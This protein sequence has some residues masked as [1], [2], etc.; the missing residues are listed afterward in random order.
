MNESGSEKQHLYVELW[1]PKQTWLD[2]SKE[3]RQEYFNKVGGE[4]QKLANEGIKVLGF[5]IN[6]K[7]TP[8]RSKHQY[9]AVWQ[10]PSKKHVEM[11]EE[12]V[13][14]TGWYNYFEQVNARGEL[15]PPPVALEN[16]LRLE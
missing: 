13:S 9:V 2:L 11:L 7:E 8:Y 12:S 10:M 14:Q 16:M 6:D 3:E 4:M 1:T 5:A 15:I